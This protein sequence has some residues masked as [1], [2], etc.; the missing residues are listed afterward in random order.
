MDV[1][2]DASDQSRLLRRTGEAAGAAGKYDLA[3][4][5]LRRGVAA[6]REA[7]HPPSEAQSVASLGRLLASGAQPAVAISEITAALPALSGLGQDASIVAVWAALSRAYM[8][9]G[10]FGPSVEWADRALPLAERL[11]MVPE[12]ADLLNTRATALGFGGR[13][14]EGVAGLRGVLEMSD[15]YGLSYAGIRARVNL[16]S[17]LAAEDPQAGFRLAFE[18]FEV[19]KRAGSRD[20]M[21]T[22]GA[23]A[24]E[25]AIHVGEWDSAEAILADL[26]AADLA[27]PDRFVADVYTS[28]LE[29]LRGRPSEAGTARAETFGE[30]TDEPVVLSQ[31]HALK[32]WVALAEGRFADAHESF[33]ADVAAIPDGASADLPLVGRAALWAGLPEGARAAAEQLRKLGFHGRAIHA[34]TRAIDG[35]IAAL[36]G[37][38]EEAAVAFR[39]AMRQWRDLECWFDLAL[40]ELDFVKFVEGESPDT[41]AA[42]SE[43]RSIFTRLGAPAF[44]RRL[45]EAVGLPKS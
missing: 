4:G 26:L 40:C 36:S 15:S 39:D 12:I 3:E 35:G 19:A 28:I 2:A 37:N 23:N 7:G 22:M 43:A 31:L 21:A 8:L 5:Y 27:P 6:A 1:T 11:D 38:L 24:S 33:A 25:L 18:G 32:G 20:M 29:A 42:A 41:E 14:R 10:E 9:H 45:D 30:T 16:S 17:L 34:S 44:L 13:V